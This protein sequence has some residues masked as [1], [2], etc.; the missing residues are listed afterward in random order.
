M[1]SMTIISGIKMN[2]TEEDLRHRITVL[3]ESH[4]YG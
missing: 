3:E 2:D 4:P 1:V